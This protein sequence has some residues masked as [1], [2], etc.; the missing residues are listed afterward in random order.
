[1][2][3][4]DAFIRMAKQ[5][6]S[7]NNDN[8]DDNAD[9]IRFR[10]TKETEILLI[11]FTNIHESLDWLY[12]KLSYYFDI[13]DKCLNDTKH[14]DALTQTTV[15]SGYASR[16]LKQNHH[17]YDQ[18]KLSRVNL[19]I[20]SNA[21]KTTLTLPYDILLPRSSN[22]TIPIGSDVGSVDLDCFYHLPLLFCNAS[23]YEYVDD[24]DSDENT[25]TLSCDLTRLQETLHPS[26]NEKKFSFLFQSLGFILATILICSAPHFNHI[27]E[28][29]VAKIYRNIFAIE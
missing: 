5:Q 8:Q 1:M 10:Q 20:F 12:C 11:N 28:T 24:T 6:H 14:L 21:M 4:F 3:A 27:T 29:D 22:P 25:M 2:P 15:T 23:H 9:N 13:L 7:T 19:E 26:L 18:L 16:S 17:Q